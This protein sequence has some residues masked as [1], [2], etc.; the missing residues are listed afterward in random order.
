M[1]FSST[2]SLE[3]CSASLSPSFQKYKMGMM[4]WA[5]QEYCEVMHVKR[6]KLHPCIF[7]PEHRLWSRKDSALNPE[8][9]LARVSPWARDLTTKS[10]L[11]H[12]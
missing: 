5:L 9:D 6:L 8:S 12:L 1:C 7:I 10:Q 4:I 11:P 3:G 2:V